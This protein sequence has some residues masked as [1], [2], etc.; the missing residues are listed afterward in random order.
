M[1]GAQVTRAR[2]ITELPASSPSR[3]VALAKRAGADGAEVLVRDGS[4]AG[5]SR[6]ASASPSWCKEAGSR[7]ARPARA[8]GRRARGHL[9]LAIFAARRSSALCA[10]IG[11]AGRARRA[12]RARRAAAARASWRRR[13]PELDLW[14]DAALVASTSPR[15]RSSAQ[16]PARRRRARSTREVT[17][18]E[19]ATFGRASS[20]RGA[21]A[22]SAGFSGG[23]R[24]TYA[25]LVVEPIC[26]D[27]ER[28]EAQRLLLDRRRASSAGCTIPRRSASRRRAA[29]SPSSAR[30][31][32]TTGELPV[33]FDPRRAAAL[34]ARSSSGVISGGAIWRKSSYLVGREGD[35]GRVAAGH[36]RRRSAASRARPARAP[37]TARA[38]RSRKNVVVDGG[39]LGPSSA[40]STRRASSAASRPARA[41]RGV[42]GAPAR[43]PPRTSS[44]SQGASTPAADHRAASRAAS[45]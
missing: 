19:G 17:N 10:E 20:A 1:S 3:C 22:T 24:G 44:C 23:Y 33:V 2:P 6:S 29:P 45:T 32:S 37:S 30:A 21:F 15:A 16:A 39:M 36:D 26:D 27:A 4:R 43:R 9:H 12:R 5:R 34:L 7:G 40:T 14:D 28:Q 35:A 11:R 31:R 42:G 25:S 41:G 8:H 13:M 38:C 18:S